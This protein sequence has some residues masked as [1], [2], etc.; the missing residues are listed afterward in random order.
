MWYIKPLIN[1]NNNFNQKLYFDDVDHLIEKDTRSVKI[2][3]FKK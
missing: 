2:K 3:K 1:L